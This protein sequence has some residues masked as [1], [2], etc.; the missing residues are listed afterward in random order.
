MRLL[1]ERKAGGSGNRFD[2]TVGAVLRLLTFGVPGGSICAIRWLP[3]DE[4][5]LGQLTNPTYSEDRRMVGRLLIPV[6]R[7]DFVALHCLFGANFFVSAPGRIRTC[8]P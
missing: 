5:A 4:W 8:G 2:V 7:V 3:G 6:G 1:P